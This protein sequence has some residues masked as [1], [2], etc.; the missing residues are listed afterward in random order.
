MEEAGIL[1]EP[2]AAEHQIAVSYMSRDLRGRL[3]SFFA[4]DQR[5]ARIVAKTTEPMLGQMRLAWWR[6]MLAKATEERPRGDAVLD[7]LG[8]EWGEEA[9]EFSAVV[10]GWE[11][12][13]GEPPL[14]EDALM[15]F[16][17]GRIAPLRALMRRDERSSAKE[18]SL[19]A[20]RRWALVDAAANTT[21]GN[22]KLLML[23]LAR[24]QGNP[25]ARF[26]R[27]FRGLAVLDALARRSLYRGGRPLMDGRG[28]AIV[29]L[30]AGIFGR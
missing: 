7:A 13:L 8:K 28:A 4:F 9:A 10:D 1:A 21:E 26:G 15:Q 30:R 2:L 22:E 12:M 19:A 18:A 14:G 6:D 25:S 5:L 20:L 11:H 24:S 27:G 3:A 29:A 23:E 17:G 16:A